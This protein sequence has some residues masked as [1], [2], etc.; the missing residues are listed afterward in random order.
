MVN[1]L[2]M[3]ITRLAKIVMCLVL[4][5]FC[6]LIAYD[7]IADYNANYEFV[8]HVMSMDT[9][10]P[11]NELRYSRHHQSNPLADLLRADH[12]CRGPHRRTFPRRRQ[13]R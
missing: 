3:L 5:V 11:G 1:S 8:Q 12:Y 2:A 9:T 7:N 13:F 4:A 6:L 10:F